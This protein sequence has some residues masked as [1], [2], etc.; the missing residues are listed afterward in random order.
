M[1]LF[2]LRNESL[3]VGLCSDIFL[4]SAS[5]P[6]RDS[7]AKVTRFHQWVHVTLYGVLPGGKP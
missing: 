3:I 4:I 1:D 7:K 2:A 6:I 5:R